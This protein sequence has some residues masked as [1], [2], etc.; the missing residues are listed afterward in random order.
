MPN[1]LQAVPARN[2]ETLSLDELYWL[3]T[4]KNYQVFT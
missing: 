3:P 4:R 2:Q 1:V